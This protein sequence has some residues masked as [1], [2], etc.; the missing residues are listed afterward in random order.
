MSCAPSTLGSIVN[1]TAADRC[2]LCRT[3]QEAELQTVEP[4]ELT[5]AVRHIL[6]VPAAGGAS[7]GVPAVNRL[8]P[9]IAALRDAGKTLTCHWDPT[10][11]TEAA[12]S[13]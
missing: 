7:P 2:S 4:A 13:W 3:L 9:I 1:E 10:L 6:G 12:F 5:A 8:A 11:P